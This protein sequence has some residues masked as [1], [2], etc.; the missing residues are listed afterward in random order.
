MEPSADEYR[1][2]LSRV[3]AAATFRSSPKL[4]ELLS[5][6]VEQKLA[7]HGDRLKGYP[8]ALDVFGRDEDFDASSDSIVR[9]QMTRLRRALGEYY[10]GEGAG[11]PFRLVVPRGSYAPMLE[12]AAERGQEA[13][14]EPS[15]E[16]PVDTSTSPRA[17]QGED[18]VR[19]SSALN[20]R[21]R[22]WGLLAALALAASLLIIYWPGGERDAVL[23]R[24]GEMPDGPV[25]YV[26]PYA[27]TGSDPAIARVRDGLQF[28]LINY[29]AQL[30]NLAVL[31]LD[32]R[33]AKGER[34]LGAGG[35]LGT[36][37]SRKGLRPAFVL[38]GSI[39]GAG[40]T[41]RI[42][43]SLVRMP[44]GVVVWSGRSASID[45]DPAQILKV[46]SK[47]ALGVASRLGQPYGVIHE[48]MR[49]DLENHR[50]LG[51]ERYFCEL[52]A[53]EFMR[54]RREGQLG[55]VKECLERAVYDKPNYSDAWA[56]LSW[57]HLYEAQAH[58]V[59]DSPEALEAAKR[60]VAANATNAIGYE[61]LAL[62][63]YRH[64]EDD[65]ARE[66]IGK[67]LEISPNH[68]EV[69]AN[70]GRVLGAL[71]EHEIAPT[72]ARKAI[73]LN[74]GH[75]PWYWS[76]LALDA[77]YRDE[78]DEALRYARL[79]AADGGLMSRYL[80]ASAYAQAGKGAEARRVL[81]EAAR[82]YPGV[83]K[84]RRE[85]VRQLRIPDFAAEPLEAQGLLTR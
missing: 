82:A 75:P 43:S 16:A 57:M 71:G 50:D 68:S 29:L 40:S 11:D 30:P 22:S 9:V 49:Q 45:Y 8:I 36:Q 38:Q 4:A 26:A 56:L 74:P 24:A 81:E 21:R 33:T 59:G 64:G 53:Y 19:S 27:I 13:R 73:Q 5:Y 2:A 63:L 51:M 18:I 44:G 52:E 6:L 46:Q 65:A 69:L 39:D 78:A 70:A 17:Q 84:D 67:A 76:G 15:P 3:V 83:S 48:T 23:V 34:Q 10:A 42:N 14:Q 35:A 72:L 20:L 25:V 79:G 47:I 62:A 1:D 85:V 7:G 55:R 58:G 12:P 37:P 54:S 28:D 60:A 31:S 32:E 77:L 41:L 66:A 61:Y 80:L